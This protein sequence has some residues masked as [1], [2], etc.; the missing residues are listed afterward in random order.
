[1][2]AIQALKTRRSVRVYS[3][4]PVPR[5][6]LEDIVDCARLAPTAMNDQPWEFVVVTDAEMRRRI[7]E[8]TGHAK[9]VADA[10]ACVVVLARQ[11]D[12]YL[13][14]TCAATENLLLAATAHG[15]GACWVAAEK[16]AYAPEICRLVGAPDSFRCV[17]AVSIG[18]P[19]EQPQVEKRALTG[20]L[21]W[22]KF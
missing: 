13:E 4:E 10:P 22:E 12:Y 16:Q 9:F 20:V 8:T 19:A 3:A 5:L 11:T 14:D 17:A 15:L 18:Y 6:I 1:M 21:H 7:A 2:D